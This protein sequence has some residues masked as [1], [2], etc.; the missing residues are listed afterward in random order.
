MKEKILSIFIF[1]FL[2]II[3]G[4][5]SV[6]AASCGISVTGNDV[7]IGQ[8]VTIT[9]SFTQPATSASF[10]LNYDST[11]VQYISNS[12]GGRNTGSSVVVDYLSMDLTPITSATFT[13]STKSAGTANFSVSGI[14]LSAANLE[15]YSISYNNGK[16]ITIKEKPVVNPDPK[17]EQPEQPGQPEKPT[18]PTQPEQPTTPTQPDQPKE[19]TF[20]SDNSKVYATANVN[21]R[22]SWTTEN[23]SN[24]LGLLKK[25]E[26][27]TRTGISSEWDRVTYKGRVAYIRHGYLT[28]TKP[29]EEDNNTVNENPVDDNVVGNIVDNTVVG[30]NNTN[31]ENTNANLNEE[32]S[33]AGENNIIEN[34]IEGKG[35]TNGKIIA[36]VISAAAIIVVGIIMF[37]IYKKVNDEDDDEDEE[38]VTKKTT[39]TT[40]TGNNRTTTRNT[41][42]RS[43]STRNTTARNTTKK[44][45]QNKSTTGKKQ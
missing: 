44:N 19:P 20:R 35:K 13:F 7:E 10:R 4:M 32:N 31:T 12:A 21:V 39:K 23:S 43:T 9:V 30:E 22:S 14:T 27:I 8:N 18:T 36:I 24:I 38:E 40:T 28:T 6:N 2:L 17:P 25:G 45:T 29:E 5:T 1:A 26:E 16:T 11:K 34:N 42:A 15:E 33:V 37:L 41:V 3:I